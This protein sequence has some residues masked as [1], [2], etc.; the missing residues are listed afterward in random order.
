MVLTLW[1]V[2][3]SCKYQHIVLYLLYEKITSTWGV[4]L[5]QL[6]KLLS[7]DWK[8]TGS[9][10]VN[11]LLCKNRVRLRTIHQMVGPLPGPCVCGSFKCT[12]LPFLKIT[13]TWNWR[14]CDYFP[15]YGRTYKPTL[16]D[17]GSFLAF[18]WV[19]TRADNTCGEPLVA[20]CSTPVSPGIIVTP[21]LNFFINYLWC[22]WCVFCVNRSDVDCGV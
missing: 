1:Y 3:Q 6:V 21:S 19:P 15:C 11:S 4:T 10:P 16:K 20:I 7:C 22:F 12:G 2:G 13:S 9:S 5:A 17:V 18:Y 8:V 14:L